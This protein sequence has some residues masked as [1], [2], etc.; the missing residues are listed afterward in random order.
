M[1]ASF[2]KSGSRNTIQCPWHK[3]ARGYT[4]QFCSQDA[5]RMHYRQITYEVT[6]IS[7]EHYK[8][9]SVIVDFAM[10]QIPRTTERIS[11]FK[12]KQS[13]TACFRQGE[14]GLEPDSGSGLIPKFNRDFRVQG[15]ICNKIFIKIGSHCPEIWACAKNALSRNVEESFRELL[16]PNPEADDSQNLTISSLCTDTSVVKFSWRTVQ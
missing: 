4:I 6:L 12:Q 10:G 8:K 5:L 2:R 14:C 7:S 3:P 15:Y 13:E 1:F 11:S 9:S 16:D